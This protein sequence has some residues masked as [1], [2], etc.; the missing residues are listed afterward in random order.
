MA[1]HP[2]STRT[3]LGRVRGLGSAKSGT[4]AFWHQRLTGL[5]LVALSIAFI[6]IAVAVSGKDY[7]TVRTIVASPLVGILIV[8]FVLSGVYH[9]QIGMQVIIEDY[10]HTEALKMVA[11][12]ANTFFAVAIGLACIF[13][14]LRIAF[15]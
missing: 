15:V 13:A 9:M 6:W 5:A 8:L 14:V 3:A 7:N 12:I 1:A 11:L 10:V 4:T 2:L